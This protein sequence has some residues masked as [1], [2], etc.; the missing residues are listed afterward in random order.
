MQED[1]KKNSDIDKESLRVEYQELSRCR[2]HD[3]TIA[4]AVGSVIVPIA[5][6]LMGLSLNFPKHEYYLGT[7]SIA[8]LW[9][10]N[11]LYE[12]LWWHSHI[13][14]QRLIKIESLLSMKHWTLIRR[15]PKEMKRGLG[16]VIRVKYLRNALCI[17]F[18][19]IWVIIWLT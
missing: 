19:V 5:L 1:M 13:R 17:I 2:T 6:T 15:P 18:T 14:L 12:K 4:W 9:F 7:A 16:P 3:D 10:W 8:L 11:L